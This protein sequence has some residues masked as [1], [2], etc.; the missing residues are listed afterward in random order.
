MRIGRLAHQVDVETSTIRF[1]ESVGLLPEPSRTPSGYRDYDEDDVARL[2]FIRNARRLGLG[3]DAIGDIL[4]FRDRGQ[5]P[6]GHVVALL[7]KQRRTIDRRIAELE[8]TRAELDRLVDLAGTLPPMD[9]DHTCMCHIID[10]SVNPSATDSSRKGHDR[11]DE[12][13]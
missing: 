8:E 9:P 2:G 5:A 6:C 12:G 4:A 10:A 13:L 1:Y 11:A 7:S 3:L